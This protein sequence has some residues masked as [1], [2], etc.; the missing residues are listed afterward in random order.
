MDAEKR[1]ERA[2]E[3][4]FTYANIDGAHHKQ[5]CIDQMVRALCGSEEEYNKFVAEYE[6]EEDDDGEKQYEWSRGIAP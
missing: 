5:W 3:Y 1:V 2:L 4:A 6:G